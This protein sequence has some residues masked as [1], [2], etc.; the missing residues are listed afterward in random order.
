MTSVSHLLRS[1]FLWACDGSKTDAAA[2]STLPVLAAESAKR[3]RGGF[4]RLAAAA[5]IAKWGG[6][7]KNGP[8]AITYQGNKVPYIV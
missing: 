6:R 1:W 5:D 3:V 7:K 2:A 8:L 4:A